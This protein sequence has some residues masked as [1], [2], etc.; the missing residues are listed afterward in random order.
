[1]HGFDW[2]GVWLPLCMT[3]LECMCSKA[4]HNWTKYLLRGEEEK[5]EGEEGR[6]TKGN[7]S[8]TKLSF[9]E[10]IVFSF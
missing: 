10:L 7:I 2:M 1:M 3:R 4:L 8:L 5:K 9:L 6:D